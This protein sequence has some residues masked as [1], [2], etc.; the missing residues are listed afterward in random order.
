MKRMT[1]VVVLAL[2]A[3]SGGAA[4]ADDGD[5]FRKGK[6]AFDIGHFAD[7]A[8]EY[9]MAYTANGKSAVLFNLGEAH[10]LAGDRAEAVIAYQA[11]LRNVPTT[12]KRAEVEQ[13]LAEL[14]EAP[15]PSPAPVAR[16][17]VAPS[18]PPQVLASP[19]PKRPL[20]KKWWFWTVT[21]V[22]ASAAVTAIAVGVTQGQPHETSFQLR[23]P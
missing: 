16:E 22:V 13:R 4:R 23:M 9:E 14:Q 6:R 1:K 2:L 21:G 3:L 11:Y 19:P 17:E 5:H 10:R 8:K 20:Y 7:A 15:P 18:L 12:P